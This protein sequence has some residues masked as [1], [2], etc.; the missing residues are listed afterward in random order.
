[1]CLFD[2]FD[3]SIENPLGSTRSGTDRNGKKWS[4]EM[5]VDYGYFK[6]TTGAD[7]DHID[8]M[9]GEK[10]GTGQSVRCRSNRPRNR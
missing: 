10:A 8:V 3:I 7:K 6:G 4:V 2:G 5:P 9:I 1:M